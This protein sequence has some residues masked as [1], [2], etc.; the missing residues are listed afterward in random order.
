MITVGIASKTPEQ[1]EEPNV[2]RGLHATELAS[3]CRH[4]GHSICSEPLGA[5]G[6]P[7]PHPFSDLQRFAKFS[8]IIK[9]LTAPGAQRVICPSVFA[10][11]SRT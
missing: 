5:P 11:S 6:P 8:A 10:K 2:S 7:P 3:F 4:T 9:S 1:A